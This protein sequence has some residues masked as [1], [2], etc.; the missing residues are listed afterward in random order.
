[1]HRLRE[2]Y[3]L[4]M[5]VL[6]A[7]SIIV[8]TEARSASYSST[9]LFTQTVLWKKKVKIYSICEK[10]EERLAAVLAEKASQEN[11]S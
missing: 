4:S 6:A 1:M 8:Q 9:M 5:I 2:H 7:K 11:V 3:H 10:T